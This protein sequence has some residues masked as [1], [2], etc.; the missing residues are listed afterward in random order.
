MVG[1]E[2]VLILQL[3]LSVNQSI[4][5]LFEKKCTY[6]LYYSHSF[7]RECYNLS[8]VH[9]VIYVTISSFLVLAL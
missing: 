5:S 2:C 4:N 7:F 8:R 3:N 9:I 1:G 6:K